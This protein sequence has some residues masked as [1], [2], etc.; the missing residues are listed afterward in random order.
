MLFDGELLHADDLEIGRNVP[1]P[2]LLAHP[3]VLLRG[4]VAGLAVD[5]RLL[6]GGLVRVRLEVV[7]C[8]H[9]A[10]VTAEAGRVEGVGLILPEDGG[11]GALRIGEMADAARGRVEPFLLVDVVG[12]GERLQLAPLERREEIVD[13][14]PADD[15]LHRVFLLA[16]GALL[17]DPART[18][19]DI[20][21]VAVLSDGD[22]V[23]LGSEFGLCECGRV[24][25]KRKAV[26]R[27]GPELVE[28][29]VAIDAAPRARIALVE[30]HRVDLVLSRGRHI[31]LFGLDPDG[32]DQDE[33]EKKDF[34]D[35]MPPPLLPGMR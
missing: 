28:L 5:P 15:L 32:Q 2:R 8:A 35:L 18:V 16:V 14:L 30:V 3:V 10:D 17:D 6:P 13:V 22:F 4:A 20:R 29:L 11:V 31:F 7:L 34:Q 33:D 25:L 9:L 12:D 21:P 1:L 19:R 23:C 27:G 26:E 24:R